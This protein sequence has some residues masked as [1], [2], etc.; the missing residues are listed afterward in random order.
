[1]LRVTSRIQ[2]PP[3]EFDF[4]FARSGGPG[5]QN[6]NKVNS[7]AT[8]RWRPAESP[9][10]PDDVR[11]RFLQRHGNRITAA[12]ELVINSQKYRDQGRNVADCLEKLREMLLAV[13]V[14]PKKRRPTRPTLASQQRRRENKSLQ[15]KKK[16]S[17]RTPVVE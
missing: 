9:S 16:Q 7:K 8:L 13:A 3:T 10:L 11:Q 12:G 17:R 1:M 14:A 5:G 6:V 2:I 15:S 4:S